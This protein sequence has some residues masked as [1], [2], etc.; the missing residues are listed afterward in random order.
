[1]LIKNQLLQYKLNKNLLIN[2]GF[3]FPYF[4]DPYISLYYAS[5]KYCVNL[6]S[7]SYHN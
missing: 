6:G 2:I 1:M 3:I 4:T 7:I 5:Y